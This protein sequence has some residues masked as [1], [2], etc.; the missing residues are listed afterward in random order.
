V[1][2]LGEAL[3]SYA[4][5]GATWDAARARGKLRDL[6]VRRRIGVRLRPS[7][8]WSGLTESELR[9][10]RL[11]ARGLTNRQ[12]GERLFLSPH[13]VSSHLRHT[14]TKLEITSR[15]ELARMA[16]QHEPARA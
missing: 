5:L 10:A 4:R 9:V 14:F 6:G 15:V 1:Q 13:T 16:T 2:S 3:E 8:G 7:A 12:I 11:A